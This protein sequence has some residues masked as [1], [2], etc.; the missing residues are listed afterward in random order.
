[1]EYL[2]E[3]RSSRSDPPEGEFFAKLGP[4]V[5]FKILAWLAKSA[6]RNPR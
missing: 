5:G 1:M 3:V 4:S 6:S 2:E